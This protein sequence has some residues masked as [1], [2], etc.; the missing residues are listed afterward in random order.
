M[1]PMT[2]NPPEYIIDSSALLAICLNEPEAEKMEWQL[3]RAREGKSSLFLSV[4]QYGEILSIIPV[5]RSTAEEAATAKARGG[6]SYPDA[7]VIATAK[8]RHAIILT[9]D[10]E[11]QKFSKEVSI[12]W[13][14]S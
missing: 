1:L 14:S 10:R 12:E 13:L 9:K 7:L 5:D 4:V 3:I 8:D 2:K 6:I 11:F